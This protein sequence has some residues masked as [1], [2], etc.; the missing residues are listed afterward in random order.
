M[1]ILLKINNLEEN[2]ENLEKEEPSG[3]HSTL[4]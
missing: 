4:F 2:V 3:E 1:G